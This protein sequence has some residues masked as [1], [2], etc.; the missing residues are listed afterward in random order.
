MKG[1][2]S[3]GLDADKKR[4]RRYET[5]RGKK[6]DAERKLREILTALGKSLPIDTAKLTAGELLDK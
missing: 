5:V 4:I 3:L 1:S 6:A 2:I